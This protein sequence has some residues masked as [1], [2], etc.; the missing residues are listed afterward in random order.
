M[1]F[2]E[3]FIARIREWINEGAGR[4]VAIGVVAVVVL[5]A[6]W[7]AYSRV[8]GPSRAELVMA[9]GRPVLVICEKCGKTGTQTVGWLDP[10]PVVCPHC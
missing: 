8:T 7:M 3:G 2:D 6:G 1:S 5:G 10:F 4:Y 9:K